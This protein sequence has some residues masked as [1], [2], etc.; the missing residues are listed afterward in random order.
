MSKFTTRTQVVIV[1][2]AHQDTMAGHTYAGR[3]GT[4][5]RAL[6]PKKHQGFRH[7]VAIAEGRN[8]ARLVEFYDDEVAYPWQVNP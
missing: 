3:S 4:Y 6:K 1:D 7:L 5:V 2:G 8:D